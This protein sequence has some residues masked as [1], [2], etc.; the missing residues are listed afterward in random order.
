MVRVRPDPQ[1]STSSHGPAPAPERHP[2]F[3]AVL[4]RPR[5]GGAGFSQT[6]FPLFV[7]NAASTPTNPCCLLL[8]AVV[9]PLPKHHMI[10]VHFL[11]RGLGGTQR[12]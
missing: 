10:Q 2:T 6:K 4:W 7:G 8:L 12:R 9:N 3:C 1:I 5:A 11:R